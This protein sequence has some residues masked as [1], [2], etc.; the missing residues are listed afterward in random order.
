MTVCYDGRFA[1]YPLA[2]LENLTFAYAITI[3][4]AMGSEYDYVIIPILRNH[5]VL[6]NRNLVYTAITRAKQKVMLVGQR[7]MLYAAILRQK[8]DRR[9]TLFGRR[10]QLYYK[11]LLKKSSLQANGEWKEAV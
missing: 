4:R 3:H 2:S 11:A 9:N 5:A 1:S 8:V 6:L 7:D 10:V